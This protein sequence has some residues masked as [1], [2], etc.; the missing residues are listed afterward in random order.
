MFASLVVVFPTPHKGGVLQLRHRGNDW[1]FDSGKILEEQSTP[2]VAYI[3]FFSDVEHNVSPILSGYR[4]TLTYN[5]FFASPTEVPVSWPVV[6]SNE[7][8]FKATLSKLLA[9][10]SFLSTGG[11]LG[12]GLRYQYPVEFDKNIYISGSGFKMEKKLPALMR[13]LKG[14][15][16]IVT[17]VC[18]ELSLEAS[19]RVV[20]ETRD[21][22]VMCDGV[23]DLQQYQFGNDLA[24]DVLVGER[25]GEIIKFLRPVH[26]RY[27]SRSYDEDD[28]VEV[29]WV[30]ELTAFTR[31]ETTYIAYGND[32]SVGHMY[33]DIC[34]I[35]CV[36][37]AGDRATLF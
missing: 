10:P 31:S 21:A 24:E 23:Y 36:G 22:L 4:V 12:F 1:T 6:S 15:D 18:T 9:N 27:I 30:T 11:T 19:L 20:Y 37:E 26:D 5:L 32:A 3:A 25:G 16:G 13:H 33:G 29:T 17:R 28:L 8:A 2:S 35:V 34:L 14:S 7:L